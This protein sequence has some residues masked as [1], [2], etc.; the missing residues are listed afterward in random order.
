MK[1]EPAFAQ[2]L[3]SMG[4]TAGALSRPENFMALVASL[5]GGELDR[6]YVVFLRDTLTRALQLAGAEPMP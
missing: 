2:I 1:T 3:I 5:Q 4:F 6:G